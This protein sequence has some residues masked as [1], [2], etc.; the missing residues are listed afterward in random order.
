MFIYYNVSFI[1]LLNLYSLI[2][3]IILFERTMFHAVILAEKCISCHFMVRGHSGVNLV[4][5]LGGRGSGSKIFRFFQ[6]NFR[7]NSIFQDWRPWWVIHS[8]RP[9][10]NIYDVHKKIRVLTPLCP[11]AS[12]W[13]GHTPRLWTSTPLAVDMKY[14]S[15]SWN[16]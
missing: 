12:T 14:T 10:E 15:I 5:N 16:S 6:A 3:K 9:Q 4:W 1:G 13:A 2:D 11:H 8:W 7:K